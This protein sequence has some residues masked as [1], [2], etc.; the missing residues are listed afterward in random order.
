MKYISNSYEDTQKIAAEFAK[1]LKFSNIGFE[2]PKT[3][4][5]TNTPLINLLI[6]LEST[7]KSEVTDVSQ[8]VI[9]KIRIISDADFL[10]I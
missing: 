1:T 9:K 3:I 5:A 4:G 10:I 8:P 6:L 2:I 7:S